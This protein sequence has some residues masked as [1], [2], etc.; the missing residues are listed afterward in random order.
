MRDAGEVQRR[1]CPASTAA[2]TTQVASSSSTATHEAPAHPRDAAPA[3]AARST[4]AAPPSCGPSPGR[5]RAA[6]RSPSTI[7]IGRR[8]RDAPER[9]AAGTRQAASS[10]IRAVIFD[11]PSLALAEDD[12]QLGDPQAAPQRAVGQLDLEGVA[13]RADRRVVDRLAARAAR[14]HLKPPV[15][16][17]TGTRR[18]RAR[19]QAAA[20]RDDAPEQRPVLDAAAGHVARAEREVGAVAHRGQQARQVGRVVREPSASI[21]KTSVAPRRQRVRRSRRRRRRRGPALAGAAQHLDAVERRGDVAPS[22]PASCRRR[23][24]CAPPGS[25]ARAR[26]DHARDVLRLVVGREDDPGRHRARYG[27]PRP[28]PT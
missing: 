15:R 10:A 12:R 1:R 3:R 17:R 11:S 24:G 25:A 28:W 8:E 2:A 20:A 14:K 4:R 21:S 6:P 7:G 22:R 13:V 16:S 27:R 18:T 5:V 26:G 9:A 23:R 19:V